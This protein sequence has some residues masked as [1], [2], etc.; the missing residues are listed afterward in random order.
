MA[1]GPYSKTNAALQCHVNPIM[2]PL[3]KARLEL[4]HRTK[5]PPTIDKSAIITGLCT[6]LCTVLGIW[7]SGRLSPQGDLPLSKA[8]LSSIGSGAATVFLGLLAYTYQLWRRD[9]KRE[10]IRFA[11]EMGRHICGC[12][13]A[14]EIM[15]LKQTPTPGREYVCP[16]CGE[17]QIVMNDRKVTP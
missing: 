12:T 1:R 5:E 11:R 9:R 10:R 14:G 15:L 3:M 2:L 6:L 16:K 7:L 13:E 8:T 4:A 17:F